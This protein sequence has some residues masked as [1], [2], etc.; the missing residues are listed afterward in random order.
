MFSPQ[1]RQPPFQ[2][3]YRRS[4]RH[5]AR[6]AVA[7]VQPPRPLTAAT[8]RYAMLGLLLLAVTILAVRGFGA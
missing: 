2:A 7:A 4:R 5:S 8:C 3:P 6:V 1:F